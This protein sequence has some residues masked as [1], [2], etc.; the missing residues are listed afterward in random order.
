MDAV[1]RLN[2][3]GVSLL[4][5]TLRYSRSYAKSILKEKGLKDKDLQ[6]NIYIIG[7]FIIIILYSFIPEP[8]EFD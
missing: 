8:L 3:G 5:G 1:H 6:Y 4:Y 2:G 7:V